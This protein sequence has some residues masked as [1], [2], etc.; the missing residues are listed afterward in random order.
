MS[1]GAANEVSGVPKRWNITGL[2][3]IVDIN[4]ESAIPPKIQMQLLNNATG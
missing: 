1:A 2:K 4:P 3:D